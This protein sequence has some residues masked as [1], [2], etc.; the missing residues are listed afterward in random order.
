MFTFLLAAC[1]C[2]CLLRTNFFQLLLFRLFYFLS[3]TCREKKLF[4]FSSLF[5]GLY[6][7]AV[8][9]WLMNICNIYFVLFSLSH[10][11]SRGRRNEILFCYL[12]FMSTRNFFEAPC[13]TTLNS[14]NL[15]WKRTVQNYESIIYAVDKRKILPLSRVPLVFSSQK[16]FFFWRGLEN[17]SVHDLAFTC[18]Q[19]YRW[20][21]KNIQ[22]FRKQLFSLVYVSLTLRDLKMKWLS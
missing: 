17:L 11:L 14:L 3:L 13:S 21:R 20:K 19:S 7:S 16:T 15:S 18:R 8:D 1:I 9:G 10:T 4:L 12:I 6:V 22:K 2:V 5:L